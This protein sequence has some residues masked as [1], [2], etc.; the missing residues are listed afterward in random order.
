M[1]GFYFEG[2][3]DNKEDLAMRLEETTKKALQATPD[4]IKA[5]AKDA[6]KKTFPPEEM[7]QAYE[8]LWEELN[9]DRR[10]R[11]C[12]KDPENI[13]T[14]FFDKMWQSDNKI[15]NDDTKESWDVVKAY[16]SN[17]LLILCQSFF[18]LPA[19]VGLIWVDYVTTV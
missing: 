8:S 14:M 10:K 7:V 13:E 5:M 17:I 12:K 4:E 15:L 1:P 3:L 9:Y 16:W 2:K 6:M 11:A 18:R 19:L